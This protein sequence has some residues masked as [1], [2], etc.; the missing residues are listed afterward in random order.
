MATLRAE[1]VLCLDMYRRRA[2]GFDFGTVALTIC[3]PYSALKSP[4]RVNQRRGS[5]KTKRSNLQSLGFGTQ[6]AVAWSFLARV[7]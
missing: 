7:G 5:V 6:M 3:E 2:E 4:T 1:P